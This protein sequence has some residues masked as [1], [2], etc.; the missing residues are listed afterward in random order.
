MSAAQAEPLVCP[1]CESHA[2][3]L[4]KR[5]NRYIEQ[6]L[7]IKFAKTL[8][9]SKL[10]IVLKTANCY[11]MDCV[12]KQN[13]SETD[14]TQTEKCFEGDS[15]VCELVSMHKKLLL[16]RCG[17]FDGNKTIWEWRQKYEKDIS[18]YAIP[19]K[20]E[21]V[22]KYFLECLCCGQGFW[23]VKSYRKYCSE[24]CRKEVYSQVY[25]YFRRQKRIGKCLY[26]SQSFKPKSSKAK[27]CS[28]KCRVAFHR[29]RL[30]SLEQKRESLHSGGA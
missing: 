13:C 11:C 20:D 28:G 27:F 23:S 7:T 14:K 4:N 5:K 19:L 10:C 2:V 18:G 21:Y 22:K 12:K 8:S 24:K 9:Y 30:I 29:K 1:E 17:V 16:Q 15:K 26:C 25:K 3:N 6:C